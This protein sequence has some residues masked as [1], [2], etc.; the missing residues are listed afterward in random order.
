MISTNSTKSTCA[1]CSFT[2]QM[3]NFT[4][5]AKGYTGTPDSGGGGATGLSVGII[6]ASVVSTVVGVL[7]I[8][9]VAGYAR[10]RVK[11]QRR[12]KVSTLIAFGIFLEDSDLKSSCGRWKFRYGWFKHV[13]QA[14][15]SI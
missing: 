7:L 15:E 2:P 12:N 9:L 14:G 3:V 11:R 6:V 4:C 13:W 1:G 5:S 10:M 8:G